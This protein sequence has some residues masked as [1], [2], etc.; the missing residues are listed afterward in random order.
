MI[1]L[2]TNWDNKRFLRSSNR[3][4][5]ILRRGPTLR[6]AETKTTFTKLLIKTSNKPN[7]HSLFTFK[8]AQ[9]L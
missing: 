3:D 1:T 6:F 2:D 5:V 8:T 4:I 9:K 7:M